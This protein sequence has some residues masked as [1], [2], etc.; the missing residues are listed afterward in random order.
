M[1]ID[2]KS[3]I[4]A[5][6]SKDLKSAVS[7]TKKGLAERSLSYMSY[8]KDDTSKG[9]VV[10]ADNGD[11]QGTD[12]DPALDPD[13]NKEFFLKS[14]KLN[15]IVVTIKTLGVGKNKPV[16][17]YFDDT[18]WEMFPGP[19][20]A[21]KEAKI[22]VKNGSYE[23]WKNRNERSP[24]DN[25]EEDDEEKIKT[26]ESL[27]PVISV[28]S[29]SFEV[30]IANT[31]E[32][33][34]RG[35]MFETSM[36][37]NRG[38]FFVFEN[39]DYHGIW[40]KNTYIPLDVVWIN[41]SG[42]VVDVQTLHPHDLNSKFPSSPAKY[43]LEVNAG[44]FSNEEIIGSDANFDS[45]RQTELNEVLSRKARRNIAKAS[46]RTAKRRAKSAMR[47]KKRRKTKEELL[48]KARK[49]ARDKIKKKI[50]KGRKENEL[51][52][53]AKETL[54][55]KLDKMKGKIEKI[56]KKMLAIARKQETERLKK[57]KAP[58]DEKSSAIGEDVIE[59]IKYI[60]ESNSYGIV[61]FRNGG[62]MRVDPFTA[63]TLVAVYEELN[64]R[65]R[66]KF[67]EMIN[68]NKS[69][70]M[71]VLNFSLDKAAKKDW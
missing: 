35:L 25:N 4:E 31:P 39:E 68:S 7:L 11:I 45:Y 53:G 1:R 21:E 29:K 46:R 61:E 60:E 63:S 30:D 17:V 64:K 10:E 41:E 47:K 52:L 18:R 56:A 66:F 33:I 19:I 24:S 6:S 37:S 49:M 62:T 26:N 2:S 15:D 59:T 27:I 22:F 70:F 32:T 58:K 36:D 38:M 8:L 34:M 16:S 40:M 67:R 71:K 57:M 5:L 65:N 55:K 14:F 3:I 51:S 44:S 42:K 20:K 69:G 28:G 50:L 48:V 12:D 43:V 54:E 13:L 23:E 9:L